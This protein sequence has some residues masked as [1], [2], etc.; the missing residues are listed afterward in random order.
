MVTLSSLPWFSL[1]LIGLVWSAGE[2]AIADTHPLVI[3]GDDHR[4]EIFE[5]ARPVLAELAAQATGLVMLR[6]ELPP[7]SHEPFV[8]LSQKTFAE[9]QQLCHEE[10]FDS[11]PVAGDCT[12]FLVAENLFV[13]AGH[14]IR[15]ET[16]CQNT[17]IVFDYRVKDDG[18]PPENVTWDQIFYCKKI[19]ALDLNP[20]SLSDFAIIELDRSAS[21]RTPLTLRSEG[22]VAEYDD[23]HVFG[24]P[25]GLPL[26][27]VDGNTIRSNDE[28]LTFKINS[29]TFA[30][31]SGSPVINA[32][33]LEVEGIL[34]RGETDFVLV[35]DCYEIVHCPDDGCRGE[36]V[37]R[38]SAFAKYLPDDRDHYRKKK[39]EVFDLLIGHTVPIPDNDPKGWFESF[40]L[41]FENP[42]ATISIELLIEHSFV[43]DLQLILT[44]PSG[45]DLILL[46]RIS[47]TNSRLNIRFGHGG[48]FHKALADLRGQSLPGVWSLTIADMEEQDEGLILEAKITLQGFND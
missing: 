15:N 20:S 13:T 10:R 35:G 42:I 9:D 37:L 23:L 12:G 22:Q 45:E 19:I 27:A 18:Q 43:G 41:P 28:P 14:C 3:Y 48:Q 25:S 33:T 7:I 6:S 26:K 36:D 30:G 1:V 47:Q 24:H 2:K 4:H 46:D 34:V 8:S 29:D 32:D 39:T 31:N 40:F 44:P 38:T 21:P 17:A 5:S 16:I 11:Q